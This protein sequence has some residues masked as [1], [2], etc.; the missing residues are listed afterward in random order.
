MY[1]SLTTSYP[2]L[3][4]PLSILKKYS[5]SEKNKTIFE[6]TDKNSTHSYGPVYNKILSK[7]SNR[8]H[9]RILEIGILSGSFLQV[10]HELLPNADIYGVDITLQNYIYNKNHPKIR[11]YEM[12][13]TKKE[14]AE[15]LNENFDLI[16]EDGSHIVEDQ[17]KTLD[18]FAPYL[19]KNGI[20]I[21][22]DIDGGIPDTR[23]KL[24]KVADKH[25][26]QMEWIDLRQKK[27]RYDDILAVFTKKN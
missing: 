15:F 13:G 7:I 2:D 14:T 25:N 9:V 3:L 23:Q 22:E 20:Y 24:K 21:T 10:L 18:V 6:G 4:S 1:N 11:L 26:L 19:K 16:I 5:S 12:D 17:V 27:N 8:N